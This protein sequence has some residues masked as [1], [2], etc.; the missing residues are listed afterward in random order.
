MCLCLLSRITDI[1]LTVAPEPLPEAAKEHLV[2]FMQIDH[3]SKARATLLSDIMLGPVIAGIRRVSP[4]L[5]QGDS[6]C[7]C[8]VGGSD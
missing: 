5:L 3:T 2:G 4:R 8:F 6:A 1:P 7:L